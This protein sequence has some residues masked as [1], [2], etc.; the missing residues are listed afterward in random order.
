MPMTS[1]DMSLGRLDWVDIAAQLDAEGYALL[2]GWLDADAAGRL[3]SQAQAASLPAPLEAW[4]RAFYPHL[5]AIA[6]RWNDI[7][8]A[9]G[10]YPAELADSG[11]VRAQSHLNRL[12]VG[13]YV[14]LHQ[15]GDG[16]Q[17]FPLQVVALLSV[18]GKDF[19]GGEFVMTEQRPRMQSRPMVLPLQL[20][21]AA[22]I[23]TA[24]RP[25]KGSAG[26]YRVKLRHAISRVREGQRIG[27]E[28]S[29]HDA[30]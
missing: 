12:G 22:I 9:G 11:Q 28:L 30:R 14:P 29:F 21:D 17:V 25:V 19:L 6:E 18:P 5:A 24:E 4:S 16:G 26:Y 27:M 8:G 7:L 2:P 23:A 3:A 15:R 10:R 1:P 13:D 20:G